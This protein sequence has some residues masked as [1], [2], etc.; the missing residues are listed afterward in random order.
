MIIIGNMQPSIVV[1]ARDTPFLS[2]PHH[3]TIVVHIAGMDRY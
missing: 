1:S 3:I 2:A